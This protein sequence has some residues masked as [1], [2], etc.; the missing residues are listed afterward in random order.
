MPEAHIVD[1][2]RTPACRRDLIGA[3]ANN[4][5]RGGTANVTIIERL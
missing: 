4:I 2:Q 3:Q 5:A 1:A